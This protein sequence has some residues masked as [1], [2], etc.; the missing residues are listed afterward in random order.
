MST[1]ATAAVERALDNRHREASA[2]VERIL[3]A[4]ITVMQRVAPD[5]ARVNDIIAEAGSSKKAFY[6]YFSSKE[7]LMLAILERGVTI[8][9][10]Y[11]E[12][13]MA[14]EKHPADQIACWI[15]GA[16]AQV[17]DPHLMAMSRAVNDQ[18]S[19]SL[20]GGPADDVMAPMRDL[21]I[22]PVTAL[23]GE[24]PQRDATAVFQITAATMRRN[25]GSAEQLDAGDIAHLVR[26]CLRGLGV[27]R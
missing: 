18:L 5:E 21:L 24:D 23:G 20:R 25:V 12:H 19:D 10:S 14:K 11:L 2:E 27:K 3:A 9:V 26:F 16:L 1:R 17:A 7:E 6:K 22:A 15:E 13:Q 8:I 4:T